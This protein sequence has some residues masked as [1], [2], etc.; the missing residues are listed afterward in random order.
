[1]KARNAHGTAYGRRSPD[2]R[3]QPLR[4]GRNHYG[5]WALTTLLRHSAKS[6]RF[7][8]DFL[9]ILHFAAQQ[10]A[11]CGNN[12][13]NSRLAEWLQLMG[14]LA[15]GQVILRYSDIY[16]QCVSYHYTAIWCTNLSLL[17][18]FIPDCRS[19]NC[20]YISSIIFI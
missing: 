10:W 2:Q 8:R 11:K 7:S 5:F 13:G 4:F 17:S 9:L 16:R 12:M 14:S 1:M 18:M 3:C 6:L 20:L 15:P 19:W